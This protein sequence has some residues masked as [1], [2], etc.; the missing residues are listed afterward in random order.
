MI[1][2]WCERA[3]MLG[4]LIGDRYKLDDE[5]FPNLVS[6]VKCELILVGCALNCQ[7]NLSFCSQ[8]KWRALMKNDKAVK[9]SFINGEH[10]AKYM[11]SRREGVPD[12]DMLV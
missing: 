1:W 2:P 10:H 6:K 8:V 11:I 4:F 5:R 7:I 9:A 12:Y 3:D